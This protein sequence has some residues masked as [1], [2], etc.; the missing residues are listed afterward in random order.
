M[1]KIAPILLF[2]YNRLEHTKQTIDALQL[3]DLAKDSN[4]F[5]YS[6]AEKT[7]EDEKN[8]Q[9]V[10]DYLKTISGFKKIEIVE[11]NE[12]YGLAKSII[13][14]VSDI[15][16]TYEKV[17]V[18]E[19][20]LITSPFFL[21]YMN[22]ALE[23]YKD[24]ASVYQVSGYSFPVESIDDS[25]Y[26]LPITSTWGWGTWRNSWNNFIQD[27]KPYL[28]QIKKVKKKFNFHNSYD[29]YKMLENQVEGL[30]KSWGIRW[31]LTVYLLEGK[32]VY[33]YKSHVK[34]IG[35]D[36]S[37]EHCKKTTIYD[38]DL[39][40]SKENLFPKSVDLIMEKQVVYYLKKNKIM[41]IINYL[42]SFFRR[43][44]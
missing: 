28:Q 16:N 33:P 21:D 8:V 34:N 27:A 4:L 30:N 19:D 31:Y 13:E 7:I 15:V 9:E 35:H 11:R 2:V 6:D 42:F 43:I 20:D 5:I 40:D 37:G 24:E 17:I 36:G 22:D 1:R 32:C 10:R 3:N 38:T 25:A 18:L 14:G 23:V 29:Y 26:L 41:R 39:A 12:N 44:K